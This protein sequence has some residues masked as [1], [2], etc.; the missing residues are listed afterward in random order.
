MGYIYSEGTVWPESQYIIFFYFLFWVYTLEHQIND[1]HQLTLGRPCSRKIF[2][3]CDSPYWYD[4]KS[5]Y[6]GI[7]LYEKKECRGLLLAVWSCPQ[8]FNRDPHLVLL[9]YIE[10]VGEGVA[11]VILPAPACLN[12]KDLSGVLLPRETS[13]AW[14]NTREYQK[15]K[16]RRARRKDKL[17][18]KSLF[19][20]PYHD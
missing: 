10:K 19:N 12:E 14:K 17:N 7:G 3:P 6:G 13:S 11:Q 1:A 16:C 4:L 18:Q 2:F 5:C 20:F 9:L 15:V 8:S